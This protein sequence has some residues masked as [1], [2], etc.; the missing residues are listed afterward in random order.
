MRKIAGYLLLIISLILLSWEVSLTGYSVNA[1]FQKSYLSFHLIGLVLLF[2]SLVILT[3]RKSLDYL[4]LPGGESKWKNPRLKAALET[5]KKRKIGQMY[6]ME[7]ADSEEDIL[8][9]GEKVKSGD[10]VGIDTFPLHYREYMAIAKKGEKDGK[11]PKGV[12]FENI[13][14]DENASAKLYGLLGW[15]EETIKRRPLAYK[16]DRDERYLEK[17][18]GFVHRIIS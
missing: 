6:W 17:I 9:L 13:R 15:L 12:K 5:K 18:K 10:R 1:Y 14:I 11:F 7:G 3:S 4:V 16:K 8:L 2:V